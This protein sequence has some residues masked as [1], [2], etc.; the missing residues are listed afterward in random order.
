MI[1]EDV[2]VEAVSVKESKYNDG[3]WSHGYKI[4]ESWYNIEQTSDTKLAQRGDKVKAEVQGKELLRLKVTGKG[5]LPK[6]DSKGKPAGKTFV[7]G[8]GRTP[9][10]KPVGEVVSMALSTALKCAT[11]IAVATKATSVAD[12]KTIAVELAT[13]IVSAH[14][15]EAID[16]V[17]KSSPPATKL[18]AVSNIQKTT[19]A[20]KE[21][22]QEEPVFDDDIPF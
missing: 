10:K 21:T 17:K 20:K 11:D 14:G 6:L 1:L 16:L 9:Y 7:K 18:A 3:D 8:A 15:E 5:E 4:G 22:V 2:V 19:A 13:M 12:V